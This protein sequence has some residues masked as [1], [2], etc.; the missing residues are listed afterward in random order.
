MISHNAISQARDW[1]LSQIG[2]ARY[3]TAEG[4]W[5]ETEPTLKKIQPQGMVEVIF[6]IPA[7]EEE[8][9]ITQVQLTDLYGG[10][11]TDDNVSIHCEAHNESIFFCI[12]I[13][14]DRE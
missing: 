9:E 1:F 11:L 7:S 13:Q 2:K 14:I 8:K 6:E 5:T 12:R 3:C 10:L 4:I